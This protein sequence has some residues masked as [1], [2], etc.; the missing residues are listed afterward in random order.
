MSKTPK[1][2]SPEDAY[3]APLEKA[4]DQIATPFEEFIHNQA[5]SGLVLI[6]CAIIALVVANS[7]LAKF[8]EHLQHLPFAI[9]LGSWELKKSLH[10][11]INDGL[12]AI[13]FF[14]VG[15]E[16]KRE[17]LVG[18]LADIRKAV[19][20]VT[21]AIGGMVVPALVYVAF[22]AGGD[23]QGWGIPMA[24]DIAFAVGL[25][26][27]LG[28]SIPRSLITFLVALAIVDDLGA[29]TVIALF[30]TENINLLSLAA[31][32]GTVVIL[33]GFNLVGI[34]HP[35]P[36]FLV[37]VHATLAGVIGAL[38]VPARPKYHAR[39]FS[40]H[41]RTLM[42]RFDESYKP[43]ESIISNEQQRALLQTLENAT[44]KAES[45]LQRL[46]H[47]F[48]LPVAF[49]IIPI[50]A[51]MNAGNPIQL[52]G[53]GETL[54]HPV[55]LGIITGLVLGKLV[56][57]A[58]FSWLIIKLGI[59]RLPNGAS[60][61][62]IVGVAMFGGIG[63]TMSIFI[64]DLAFTGNAELLVSAKTGI[65]LASLIAGLSGFFWLRW[66]AKP[67]QS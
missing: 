45:P 54:S 40:D 15:L 20:P 22:N 16:I 29:V 3:N 17:I 24:T 64:A 51:L 28:G 11:W 5:S 35:I 44:V 38:T 14:V 27:L 60:M 1:T 2:I 33:I 67:P 59:A 21:A 49:L 12:M 41:V 53:I 62:Q 47:Q 56:G 43:E 10:H 63:F 25:M 50:F 8:Y 7:P 46:E 4:F 55:T 65:L 30:Y 18:E 37:A 19:L 31:A 26:V 42:D 23:I 13:F 9:Q 61:S 32:A 6:V 34:R 58:G 57:I 36:Y 52:D 48:H 39:F 66:I